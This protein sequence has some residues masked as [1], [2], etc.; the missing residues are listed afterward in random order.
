VPAFLSGPPHRHPERDKVH[1]PHCG[2]LEN[3]RHRTG[4]VSRGQF[5]VDTAARDPYKGG[6]TFPRNRFV[7]RQK[8]EDMRFGAYSFSARFHDEAR[9]PEYKGSTFRGV[10]GHALRS[11]VCALRRRSCTD[12]LLASRCLYPYVFETSPL[13]GSD[14]AN[15]EGGGGGRIRQR[16]AARPHPYVIEAPP[17]ERIRYRAGETFS[18]DLLLFGRA[19]DSIP[20]FIY[21]FNE[22]GKSGIG[23]RIDGRRAGFSLV[24]VTSAGQLIYDGKEN[25]MFPADVTT[26]L[27]PLL[28]P[29]LGCT[30]PAAVTTGEMVTYPAPPTTAAPSLLP[31]SGRQATAGEIELELLT[32]LRLKYGNHL[33][34]SL[35]FHVLIRA[36]LRRI[37]ALCRYHGDGE[38]DLDYRGITARAQAVEADETGLYWFDWERYS[39]RQDQKMLMGGLMGRVRYSGKLD[40]FLP[41]LQFGEQVHLGKQTTFGLGKFKL[42]KA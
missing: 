19:N 3:R 13:N 21:A 32:P 28:N 8:G 1:I 36:T 6:Q 14:D 42:K 22:V 2:A 12:C 40:E 18:F 29:L 9:L 38:P 37:A 17:G 15:V 7:N 41:L 25:R 35:P 31:A 39:S 24:S 27:R 30:V 33:G 26:D 16:L 23:S 10:F 34:A 20:Y 11:V 5:P 4:A